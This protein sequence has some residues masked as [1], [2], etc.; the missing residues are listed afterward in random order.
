MSKINSAVTAN[1]KLWLAKGTDFSAKSLNPQEGFL[2]SRINNGVTVKELMSVSP[3][4]EVTTS[5]ILKKLIDE[6]VIVLNESEGMGQEGDSSPFEPETTEGG[7]EFAPKKDD[8]WNVKGMIFNPADLAD[9]P[10]IPEKDKKIILYLSENLDRLNYYNLLNISPAATAKDV[11]QAYYV[12]SRRFHPDVYF[13]K[14]TGSYKPLMDKIFKR[15]NQAVSVLG[16]ANSRREYDAKMV[17]QGLLSPDSLGG[18]VYSR[19]EKQQME[20]KE[21]QERRK[22]SRLRMNPMMKRIKQAKEFY[23]MA[24]DMQKQE[25]IVDAYNKIQ[26]AL[27]YDPKNDLYQA[28]ME[29][30]RRDVNRRKAYKQFKIAEA[31]EVRADVEY[32]NMF[33]EIAQ[34]N[35]REAMFQFKYANVCYDIERYPDALKFA[36]RAVKSEPKNIEY[37]MFYGQMQI[38]NK[39]RGDAVDTFKKVLAIKP[40]HSKAKAALK[41][42]KNILKMDLF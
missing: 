35:P 1:S 39:K 19:Q 8:G 41:D 28:L 24:I 22:K 14:D 9:A 40:N 32:V 3:F 18:A 42:A 6:H 17:K 7:G 2:L 26:L 10:G 4:D 23:H 15:V 11:K 21:A 20:N 38:K 37:L 30:L 13:G 29:D 33:E 27:N 12:A 36:E 31:L 25:K 5:V 34:N 16:N